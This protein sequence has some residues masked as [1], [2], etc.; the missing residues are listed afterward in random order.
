MALG[1]G[2]YCGHVVHKRVRP[3]PHALDYRVFS[4]LLDLDEIGPLAKRLRLFSYNT[5][6]V[7]SFYDKDHGAGDRTSISETARAA[8]D[9]AGLPSEGRRIFLLSYPRI[10]GY[11]FNPLSV[12]FVYAPSGDLETL[13]YEVNNTF[14]ERTSYVVPAGARQ[15]DGVYVQ[16]CAKDM[17]VSPFA[18]GHGRYGFVV[19]DPDD[20]AIVG[21][22]F[23][24]GEGPLIK[25]HFRGHR[26]DLSDASLLKLLAIYPLFTLKVIAAIHYEA[27]KL[28]FKGVPLTERHVSPRYAVSHS[29]QS[30]VED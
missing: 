20:E 21:V 29:K 19:K 26:S 12:F 11:V 1:S 23:S 18:A 16:S 4:F 8:L 22:N 25:T 15:A 3:K 24:D 30:R 14:G 9:E 27:A 17:Y 5:W 2:I 28:W 13:I 6:N 10:F 7:F